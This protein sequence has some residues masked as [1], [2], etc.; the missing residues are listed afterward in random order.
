[1]TLS[2]YIISSLTLFLHQSI[3]Y[4]IHLIVNQLTPLYL[5]LFVTTKWNNFYDY[6]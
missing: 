3:V 1:M 6:A 4:R 2:C 5:L